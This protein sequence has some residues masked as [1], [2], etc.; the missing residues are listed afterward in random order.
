[1]LIRVRRSVANDK[2]TKKKKKELDPFACSVCYVSLLVMK[3]MNPLDGFFFCFFYK[4]KKKKMNECVMSR[5]MK[6]KTDGGS[7]R[8]IFFFFFFFF[9]FHSSTKVFV[10]E[11]NK[12]SVLSRTCIVI[13]S[14]GAQKHSFLSFLILSVGNIA[15]SC[16]FLFPSFFSFFFL[17]FLF[18]ALI[19]SIIILLPFC[20]V[21][22]KKLKFYSVVKQKFG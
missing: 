10:R 15:L 14:F 18:F 3:F 5:K 1:M 19:R 11:K 22:K 20:K 12:K 9:F 8:K 7:L 13:Y 6:T 4:K 21:K 17:Y 16:L 2:E